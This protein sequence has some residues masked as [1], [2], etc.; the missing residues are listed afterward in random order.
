MIEIELLRRLKP[1]PTSREDAKIRKASLRK[2]SA[3]FRLD[4]FL[5]NEGIL[6]VGGRI[7]RADVPF[8][9]KHPAIIPR[10]GHI[11]SL[12]IRYY[13][14]RVDHQGRGFTLNEI[15]EDGLW[16]I[17]G[18]SAVA[19]YITECV[20]CRKL[21]GTVGEQKMADL[22]LDRLQ[23][24]PPFTFC[25]VD[26]FGPFYITDGRK[27]LKR[28]GVL[29]TCLSSR[30]IHLE[31][32]KTLETDSFLNALRRFLARRGPV[33]Q[34]RSDQGTN[35]T[36]A[37][38]E[39]REALTEMD[40][41]KVRSFLLERECDWFEFQMNVPA[42]SHMS[43]VWERQIR[44]ARNVFNALFLQDGKQLDEESLQTFMRETE[45]IVNSRPL[46]VANISSPSDAEPLT[47]N[48]LLTMKSRILLPPPGEFQRA[49]LYLVKRWR[50]VQ[51]LVDQFWLRWRKDFLCTLQ[52][53]PK[54]NKPRRN[55]CVGDI[56]LIKDD[57]ALRN[58]CRKARVDDVYTDDDGLV[59]KVKIVVADSSL[60]EHGERVRATSILERPV[61]K[62]VLLLKSEDARTQ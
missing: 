62:L 58:C 36:G 1:N 3:L 32:A 50:R 15:R 40:Q 35:L 27:E 30:A 52:E 17:G 53:R 24:A 13:H 9:V 57:N 37:Q 33:R 11:T 55:M 34:L 48:H 29:F 39:L 26:Y 20:M 19:E 41:N 61:Q 25:G 54:W 38:R 14:E 49:D 43:G 44:T 7:H 60:N 47:P 42:S 5:D 45:A 18:G 16:I 12:I 31:T 8:H 10:K 59:P 28:Y 56:V 6:P 2:N 46:A 23:P 22:P 21:R 4:P 51:Y